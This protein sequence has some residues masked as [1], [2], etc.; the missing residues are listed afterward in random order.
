MTSPWFVSLALSLSVLE[1]RAECPT[2]DWTTVLN[3]QTR[4]VPMRV[5]FQQAAAVLAGL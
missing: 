1:W 2:R 5:V 4:S 3:R